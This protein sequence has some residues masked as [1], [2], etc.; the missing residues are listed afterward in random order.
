MR[1][2][3]VAAGEDPSTAAADDDAAGM[4]EAANDGRE[5][6][7][8]LVARNVLAEYRRVDPGI[9]RIELFVERL[10][11]RGADV[12]LGGDAVDDLRPIDL[13]AQSSGHR[14]SDF[15][16]A[17]AERARNGDDGLADLSGA[18]R[19]LF[20]SSDDRLYDGLCVDGHDHAPFIFSSS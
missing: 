8:V 2:Q 14:A 20:E 6:M 18:R 7:H 19:R 17:G 16:A 1:T 11:Q 15:V 12:R 4:I 5:E 10:D 9:D 3:H 13:D